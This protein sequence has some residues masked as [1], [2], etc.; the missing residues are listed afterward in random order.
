MF[1]I[2]GLGTLL[3]DF[4][5]KGLSESK[6]MLY[7]CNPGGSVA[8]FLVAASRRGS[9]CACVS[10]VGDD[11]FGR[12]LKKTLADER[13]DTSGMILTK[14]YLTTFAFLT[15]RGE[16]DYEYVFFRKEAADTM[17][18][19]EEVP[20]HIIDS[21]KT[22]H[23]TSLILSAERSREAAFFA[24]DYARSKKKLITYD[25]NWRS[26]VWKN[27]ETGLTVIKNAIQYADILKVSKDELTIVTGKSNAVSAAKAVLGM[28]VR[29]LIV[30]L[31]RE[32]S[33]FYA[34]TCDGFAPAHPVEAVN[35]TGAGDCHF[36]VF[37]HEFIQKGLDIDNLEQ[38]PLLELLQ[39]ANQAAAYSVQ[40]HGGIPSIPYTKGSRNGSSRYH[41]S[42]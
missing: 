10:K 33:G 24:I 21:A 30:T 11:T 35:T 32:G 8:N 40:R 1:D 17:F 13:I 26:H 5:P 36:G 2:A 4:T 39:A 3:I 7:E 18:A 37:V 9:R 22:L 31:G 27:E 28:G 42:R 16:G 23:I 25:V 29:L 6:N 41:R 14:E 12:L 34:K 15:V 20:L 38:A 19:K